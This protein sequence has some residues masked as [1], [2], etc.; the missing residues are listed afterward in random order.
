MRIRTDGVTAREID[1]SVM[2]LDLDT[3]EYHAIGG[4]GTLMFRLLRSRDLTED[5][6]IAELLAEYEVDE[7]RL[8]ADVADFVRKLTG[9]GLLVS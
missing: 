9:A 2:V 6:L 7:Q 4:S 1:N 8:R 3:N 5:E